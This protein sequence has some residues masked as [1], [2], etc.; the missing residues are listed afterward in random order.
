[1]L[2]RKPLGTKDILPDEIRKWT[3]VEKTARELFA[4]YGYSEIR[5]PFFEH[6][7]LFARS[8]GEDTDIVEK[9]MYTFGKGEDTVTFRP[10]ITAGIVR[11]YIENS[12]HKKKAFQKLFSI[13]PAFRHERPQK[14]RSRQFHQLNV[15]AL[16]STDPYLDAEMIILASEYFNALGLKRH[17][18]KLNSTGC[19]E[20]KPIYRNE[21]KDALKQ[22]LDDLCENCKSRFERNVFRILDCKE[23]QC[24]RVTENMPVIEDHLCNSCRSHHAKVKDLLTEH[25]LAFETDKHLVRGLDYYTKTVFEFTYPG[26]GAQDAIGGGGRYDRLIEELGGPS[27]G[28]IGFALGIERI[29]LALEAEGVADN[30]TDTENTVFVATVSPEEKGYAFKVVK[31]L[32]KAGVA[33]DMDFEGRSL[34]A[35]MK[36]ANKINAA[37]TCVVGPDECEKETVKLKDMETGEEQTLSIEDAVIYIQKHR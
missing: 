3:R 5:V 9:E 1:M 30:S 36:T 16:G 23:E 37:Y 21:L 2:F 32:R 17:V 27:L 34:K 13:G 26:L 31:T 12:L 11:A 7:R 33:A 29:L 28:A 25:R 8:I 15:E 10:E 18:V 35:Q 14:G 4:R 19:G 22:N 24:R 20:C 6:T